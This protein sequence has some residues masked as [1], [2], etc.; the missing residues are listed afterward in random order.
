MK[1]GGGDGDESW[2]DSLRSTRR[3][4]GTVL[5]SLTVP[6]DPEQVAVARRFV[7]RT[8]GCHRIGTDTDTAA[9]LTS[10]VVTNAIQHTR[11]G[12]DGGTVTIVITGMPHAVLVEV[13]DEGSPGIPVVKG[14]RHAAEG[15]GLFL[16]QQLAAQWGYLA[17]AGGTTVWFV[18]RVTE[19]LGTAGLRL[20]RCL[21]DDRAWFRAVPEPG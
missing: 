1:T 8:L 12:V 14:D 18:L 11:S 9:L 13:I 10:E 2:G 21:T 16:V 15:H 19:V 7:T 17:D 6:G 5:G 3:L 4:G 20:D